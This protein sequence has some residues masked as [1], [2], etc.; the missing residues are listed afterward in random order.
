MADAM[1][2]LGPSAELG[3]LADVHDDLF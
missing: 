2:F 1:S 3:D